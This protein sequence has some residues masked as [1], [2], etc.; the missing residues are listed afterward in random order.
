MV[1]VCEL[2]VLSSRQIKQKRPTE[3]RVNIICVHMNWYRK[4]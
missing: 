1:G 3:R 2:E 4:V